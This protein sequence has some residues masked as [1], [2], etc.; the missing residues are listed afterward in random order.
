FTVYEN[1]TDAPIHVHNKDKE[2]VDIDA[3]NI[4]RN[5]GLSELSNSYP[6]ELSGGQQQRVAIARTLILNPDI[7]FLDEPTSA[8]D[9]KSTNE[10]LSLIEQMA[11]KNMTLVVVTH[12]LVFARK[13]ADRI[14]FMN[15]GKIAEQGVSLQMIDNPRS[16]ELRKFLRDFEA[17]I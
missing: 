13:V 9:P 14:I 8:L 7:V 2:Q 15:E 11:M 4:L 16:K 3:K 10:V 17:Q 5:L 6:C 1:I 12:E